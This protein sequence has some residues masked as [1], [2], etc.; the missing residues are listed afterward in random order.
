MRGWKSVLEEKM[1]LIAGWC[2][3]GNFGAKEAIVF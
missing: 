2:L 3:A 1:G